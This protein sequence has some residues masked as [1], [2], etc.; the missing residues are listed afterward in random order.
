MLPQPSEIVPQSAAVHL[1]GVQ[2]TLTVVVASI[3][4][5]STTPTTVVPATG[6]AVYTPVA[7]TM[8][9]QLGGMA[10]S[11]VVSFP[12]Y[13]AYGAVP[14]LTVKVMFPFGA[15]V[16]AAGAITKVVIGANAS[17]TAADCDGRCVAS[18]P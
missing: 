16:G 5:A 2:T 12:V 17:V 6:P 10:M 7:G 11:Q 13:Q 3:P 8:V 14:P 9:A 1:A 15:T 4:F 18:P